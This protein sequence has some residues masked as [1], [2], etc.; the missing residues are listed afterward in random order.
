MFGHIQA[1]S[2]GD[3]GNGFQL[4]FII[5][6]KETD[7]CKDALAVTDAAPLTDSFTPILRLCPLFFKDPRTENF[8]ESKSTKRNP[9]RRDNSWCQPGQ[10]FSFF[11]TAGHT[12]LHEMTHLD[13]LGSQSFHLPPPLMLYERH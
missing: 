10:P 6:C 8:L 11:E 7:A 4:N 12:F 2:S 3:S 13:Q 9:G 1:G 5:S